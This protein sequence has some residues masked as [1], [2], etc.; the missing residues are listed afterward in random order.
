MI[1]LPSPGLL[2]D[3]RAVTVVEF[4]IIAP[5][6]IMTLMATLEIGY[7]GYVTAMVEGA[8]T[9]AAR[10]ATVGDQDID[11]VKQTIIDEVGQVVDKKY[12]TVDTKSYYNFSN[13][14][15]PEKILQDIDPKG[16]YNKGDCYED[17]NN[18]GKY[19]STL[20]SADLGNADDIVNYTVTA[21]YPNLTPVSGIMGW[22]DKR[23]VQATIAVRNQPYASRAA[24]TE[25]CD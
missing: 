6:L 23:T 20:G 13:V 24:P 16:V 11:S 14:G 8:M 5:V 19:D 4:A 3:R 10:K 25:R 7:Q 9:K 2:R 22:I 1:A 12:V 17:A 15:K 21:N 18:N